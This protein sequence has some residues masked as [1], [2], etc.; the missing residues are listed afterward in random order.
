[1]LERT[2]ERVSKWLLANTDPSRRAAEIAAELGTAVPALRARLPE[3]IAGPEA[4]A[5]HKLLSELEIAGLAAP[6]ARDLATAEWLT[7]VLDVVT[8]ARESEVPPEDAAATYYALG[9][10][11]DFAWLWSRLGEAAEDDRW[12]RRAVEGLVE[13]LLRARRVLTAR[14][15]RGDG[16]AVA[17]QALTGVQDLVRDLRAAPRTSLAALQVLVREIRT[18]AEERA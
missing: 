11:L 15:L 12:Q 13:D 9:Q 16:I 8:V 5:F 10:H 4:E 3:W 7:G 17:V 6:L 2:C 14:A 1:V 18:R